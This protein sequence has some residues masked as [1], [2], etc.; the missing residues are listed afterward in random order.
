MPCRTAPKQLRNQELVEVVG[1]LRLQQE[2]PLGLRVVRVAGGHAF[3]LH[4]E[5]LGRGRELAGGRTDGRVRMGAYGWARTDG[6]V[7]LGRREDLVPQGEKRVQPLVRHESSRRSR[8][9]SRRRGSV[10]ASC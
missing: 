9:P 6:H 8:A 7:R 4:V 3:L 5:A 10:R 1:V 2:V